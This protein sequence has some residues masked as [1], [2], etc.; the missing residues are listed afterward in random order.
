MPTKLPYPLAALQRGESHDPFAVLGRQSEANGEMLRAFMPSA[1][2]VDVEGFGTMRRIPETDIFELSLDDAQAATLPQHY[3]LSWIEKADG[4][5]Y[6]Q[7]SPYSFQPLL[8]DLD[9][10]LFNE[11]RHH[12]IYRLL[13]AHLIEVDGISE[14]RFAV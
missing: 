2:T 5:R 8:P 4:E 12:H 3:R 9:L 11:G 7:I 13:D 6:S 14:C 10:H 1:E